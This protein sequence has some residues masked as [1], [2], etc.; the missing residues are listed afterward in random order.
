M[1]IAS[2]LLIV[3]LTVFASTFATAAGMK[4][5]LWEITTTTEMPGMPITPPPMTVTHCYTKEDV[6][7]QRVV[8]KQDGNCTIR[9]MKTTGSKTS[10]NMVC[11]GEN[12]GKGSGE[13]T[14]KG[15]SAY[16]GSQKFTT[17]GMTV[18]SRYKA[19]R[20]GNCK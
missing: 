11:T 20:I 13:I 8:P 19:K 16:E 1:R 12:S 18:T 2:I 4:E 10:W 15:D 17:R 6:K 3:T 14:F 7:N 5:G 9:D